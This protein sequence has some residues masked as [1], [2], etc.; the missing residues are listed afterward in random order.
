MG[1]QPPQCGFFTSV[2]SS[3]VPILWVGH[4]GETFG[5]AGSYFPVRQP[6]HVPAHPIWRWNAGFCSK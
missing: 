4:D 5:S 2:V 1:G 3:R 6:R